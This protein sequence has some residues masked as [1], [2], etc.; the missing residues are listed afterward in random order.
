MVGRP[1]SGTWA[2]SALGWGFYSD[3]IEPGIVLAFEGLSVRAYGATGETGWSVQ[4]SGGQFKAGSRLS[5]SAQLRIRR[6]A[7]LGYALVGE[8]GDAFNSGMPN[9][10]S[11]RHL[12]FIE[13]VP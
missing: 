9:P 13:I 1:A 6:D 5:L 10:L 12:F 3:V 4:V 2:G 11:Q 7:R 8:E